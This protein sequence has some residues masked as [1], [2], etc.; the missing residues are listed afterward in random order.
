MANNR[1]HRHK[2]PVKND[3]VPPFEQAVLQ[4]EITELK[5]RENTQNL[6]LNAGLKTL[7]DLVIRE[8]KDFYKIRTFNKKDLFEVK[9]A[10]RA[11]KLYNKPTAQSE[12]PQ[13][14][15][16]KNENL[17]PRQEKAEKREDRAEKA[18]RSVVRK[19]YSEELD[20]FI[21]G[22]VPERPPR[23]KIVP[24]PEKQ[25]AYVKV[26]RGGKWGFK[27]RTGKTVIEPVYDEVFT[28]HE[29]LCCVEQEEKFGFINREGE[30]V[31]PIEYDCATSFS[32]GYACVFK[33]EKCGYINVKNE[34]VVPFDYDAG[35]PVVDGEVRVKKDGRWG[36]MH[37]IASSDGTVNTTD[38]RWIV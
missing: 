14:E 18:D 28:F 19:S 5:L 4:V 36:E 15:G 12:Q 26:N 1:R 29:D 35:T 2:K 23:P 8:D 22:V 32:E 33:R 11:K 7:Y 9:N 20:A 27:E 13:Q 10:L 34:V 38:I 6:L 17:P 31:I 3:Y 24:V 37:L 30:V 21:E 25:D 16:K